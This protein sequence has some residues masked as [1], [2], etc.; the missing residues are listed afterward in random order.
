V[1]ASK[2]GMPAPITTQQQQQQAPHACQTPD[3]GPV[4]SN[5]PPN[6]HDPN[7]QQLDHTS[8]YSAECCAD[9]P[10]LYVSDVALSS[11]S[12]PLLLS[13]S[14]PWQG[15]SARQRQQQQQIKD[16]SRY[17]SNVVDLA[18]ELSVKHM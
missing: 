6:G 3:A 5:Q 17:L 9:Q 10:H 11:T 15:P 1:F 4:G 13:S 8:D 16:G 12:M 14:T 2:E 7:G 18:I